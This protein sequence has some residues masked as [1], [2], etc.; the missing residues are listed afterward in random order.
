VVDHERV[1]PSREEVRAELTRRSLDRFIAAGWQYIEPGVEFMDNWHIAAIA[2][3]LTALLRRQIRK[4]IIN[5]PPRTSKSTLGSVLFPAWAWLDDPSFKMITTSYE[6]GLAV[7]DSIKS[8]RLMDTPWYRQLNNKARLGEEIDPI[9]WMR[10]TTQRR[11]RRLKDSEDYYENDKGGVRIAVGVEGGITGKGA[12]LLATDDPQN[13]QQAHSEIERI[14][15]LTW[16]DQT[17]STRL[18]NPKTGLK[19]IIMQRLHTFDLTGHELSKNVG[20]VH[21]KLPME[22]DGRKKCVTNLGIG[23]DGKPKSWE[24]PRTVDGEALHEERFDK[25]ARDALRAALG[26]WAFA[27]QEQQ[28]PIPEGG[29]IFKVDWFKQVAQYPVFDVVAMSVDCA[30]TDSADSSYVVIQVWGFSGPNAYLV[31]QVR[32]HLSFVATEAMI[33]ATHAKWAAKR[34]TPAVVLVEN[35]ANGPAVISRLVKVL[36]GILPCE[37]RRM[38][39]SKLARA[40]S[41]SPFVSA[42]NVFLPMG[43]PWLAEFLLELSHFPVY[44]SDDQTDALSQALWWRYLSNIKVEA[45]AAKQKFLNWAKVEVE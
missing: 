16:W 17:M 30:F 21:L 14:N 33:L 15:T 25:E 4:L 26:P 10:D 36:P 19:L 20:Y 11:L 27:A 1:L 45:V 24:D 31:D 28:E 38:G 18:D 12:D 42:G 43:A 2:E 23:S 7:R 3:H 29:G 40:S 6:R 8:R 41:V 35:K 22:Y 32:E 39:G 13:P 5:I 44:G 37:P 9:F 34:L